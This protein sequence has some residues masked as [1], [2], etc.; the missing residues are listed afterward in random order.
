GAAY[1]GRHG[2]PQDRITILQNSTDTAGL[3][4]DLAQ[5]MTVDVDAFRTIHRLVHGKTGLFLGGIDS[6]KGIDFLIQAVRQIQ[7]D[8]PDFRLLVAG[9]GSEVELVKVAET[10]GLA[11]TYLGPLT[12][13]KKALALA[14]C[15][16]LLIPQ[17]VGLVATDALAAGKPIVTTDHYTHAP[18]F[19]Y[20]HEGTT[21]L[22]AAHDVTA[23]ANLAVELIRDP[24]LLQSMQTHC[25]QEGANFSIQSMGANFVGGITDWAQRDLPT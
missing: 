11:M 18:E 10:H 5:L 12:G 21:R 23:Y 16:F 13:T 14:A 1:V 4:K 22:A 8:E 6:R 20:L 3:R 19:S 25:F 17:W 24:D 2:F 7:I 15:D 9:A